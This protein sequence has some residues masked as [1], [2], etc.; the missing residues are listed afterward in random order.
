MYSIKNITTSNK[1]NNDLNVSGI[2]I[3]TCLIIAV[4][5]TIVYF[6]MT[7]TQASHRKQQNDS[8]SLLP[9]NVFLTPNFFPSFPR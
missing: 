2:P 3:Y 5:P 4:L 7:L 6:L 1:D 9:R 8:T